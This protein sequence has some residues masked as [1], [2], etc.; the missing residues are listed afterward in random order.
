[1]NLNL[2]K[3]ER[4]FAFGCSFT[5]YKWPTWADI[6]AEEIK[7]RKLYNY[8]MSGAGNLFIA[9]SISE[10]DAIH[11]LTTNDLVLVMWTNIHREDRF[12]KDQWLPAGNLYSQGYYPTSWIY[13]YDETHYLLRDLALI[14]FAKNFFEN[15]KIDHH[16]MSMVSIG[17]ALDGSDIVN[18]DQKPIIEKYDLSFIKPSIHELVFNSDWQSIK[19]RSMTRDKDAVHHI[20]GPGWAEDCHAHPL[21][22]LK[23]LKLLW[24]ETVFKKSTEEYAAY[25][26]DLVLKTTEKYDQLFEREQVLRI[27][28]LYRW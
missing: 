10:A 15:K 18:I 13:L 11:N 2:D 7:P 14:K 19:P 8:G 16:F 26:H 25:Y 3:Y 9:H 22:H 6:I 21:E 4:I 23:Y 5:N 28:K 27:H 17:C 24:P 1:M 20:K 12:F